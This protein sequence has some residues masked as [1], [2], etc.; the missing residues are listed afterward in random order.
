M[1]IRI[2]LVGHCGVDG[3]RL[4]REIAAQLNS[5]EALRVNSMEQLKRACADGAELLLVNREPLGFSPLMGI[6]LIRQL[7]EAYPDQKAILVSDQADAQA[8]AVDVGALP[9][10][11]KSDINSP[12][13]AEAL[14]RSL[15][16]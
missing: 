3:P 5:A 16:S 2:L 13:F 10:F 4:Q 6:D 11:G 15:E 7:R 9:G 14:R 8:E 12:R 1:V